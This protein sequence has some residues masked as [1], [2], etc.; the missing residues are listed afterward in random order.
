M[1]TPFT[2]MFKILLYVYFTIDPWQNTIP[3]LLKNVLIVFDSSQTL[4][5]TR[6]GNDNVQL[7]IREAYDSSN[8][9]IKYMLIGGDDF[10]HLSLVH[11]IDT[12]NINV[13][14]QSL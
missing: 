4:T 14:A 9:V 3:Y 11:N 7:W 8:S 2:L 1:K 13:T 5:N 6:I 10:S 12:V